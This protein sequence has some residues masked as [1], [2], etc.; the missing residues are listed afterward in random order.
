MLLGPQTLH[1]LSPRQEDY[2]NSEARG[3]EDSGALREAMRLGKER[4]EARKGFC[5]QPRW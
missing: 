5:A 3:T 4:L 1:R 2:F